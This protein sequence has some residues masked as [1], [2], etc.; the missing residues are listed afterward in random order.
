MQVAG[1]G[2][3]IRY[4]IESVPYLLVKLNVL[5]LIKNESNAAEKEREKKMH[6]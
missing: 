2:Y 4:W 1:G 3:N 6:V 5:K